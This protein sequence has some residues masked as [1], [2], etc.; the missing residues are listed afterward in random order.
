[1][2]TPQPDCVFFLSPKA[3]ARAHAFHVTREG[4]TVELVDGVLD[5]LHGRSCLPGEY[6]TIMDTLDC[7]IHFAVRNG[8]AV[9]VVL[10]HERDVKMSGMNEQ[11]FIVALVCAR[12][13]G[14]P[15]P[16]MKEDVEIF[17]QLVAK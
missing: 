9:E 5:E 3:Y 6:F 15:I 17:A 11:K 4:F 7:R 10:I 1:M 13:G 16:I 12:G 8:D 14:A 2:T